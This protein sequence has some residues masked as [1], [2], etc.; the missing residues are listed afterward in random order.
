MPMPP[1]VSPALPTPPELP[2]PNSHEKPIQKL[3]RPP[4]SA[5]GVDPRG[6]AYAKLHKR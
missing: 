2:R 3:Q 5:A 6:A 4:A 1:K